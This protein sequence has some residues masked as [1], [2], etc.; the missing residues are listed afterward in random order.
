LLL[1]LASHILH[2][3]ELQEQDDMP[4]Q[5]YSFGSALADGELLPSQSARRVAAVIERSKSFEYIEYRKYVCNQKGEAAVI[6]VDCLNDKVPS[7]NNYGIKN[8]ERL[9]LVFFE[10]AEIAPEL[11][12]MRKNF[13]TGIHQNPTN[14]DEAI[15]LCLYEEP[16]TSTLRH[17]TAEAHLKKILW[18]LENASTGDLH[19]EGQSLE[20]FFYPS[21]MKLVLPPDFDLILEAEDRQLLVFPNGASLLAVWKEDIS[22]LGF[23]AKRAL[24]TLVVKITPIP[25][26]SIERLPF[27][28]GGLEKVICKRSG[29]LLEILKEQIR[30]RVPEKGL[31]RYKSQHVLLII[32]IPLCREVGQPAEKSQNVGFLIEDDI[33]ALGLALDVLH[34]NEAN[35]KF[36][37]FDLLGSQESPDSINWQ[38]MKIMPVDVMSANTIALA[39]TASAI[40]D[41]TANFKG[42]LAGV[43]ALGSSLA[44]LWALEGWGQ[45]TYVDNDN[46]ETHNILRH[47]AKYA[48]TGLN[49]VHAVAQEVSN[50]YY[51]KYLR[52]SAIVDSIINFTNPDVSEAISHADLLIDASTTLEAPREIALR[53]EAPRSMSAFITPN[54]FDSVL[55]VEDRNRGI[56]LDSLEAQYYQALLENDWGNNHLDK[57]KGDIWIGRGCRDISAVIPTE[58]I[59]LHSAMLARKIRFA[60]YQNNSLISIFHSNDETGVSIYEMEPRPSMIFNVLDWTILIDTGMTEVLQVMRAQKLP[61]ETGGVLLGFI[62]HK[63]NRIF[64]VEAL[65][66]PF[67]SDETKSSFVRGTDG[68]IAILDEARRR[69]AGLVTYLGEWHS[70]PPGCGATPSCLDLK[71]I[72]YLGCELAEDGQ[73][74]LM[75]IVGENEISFM[76]RADS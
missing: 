7:R 50:N 72:D 27:T 34:F 73:P 25:H 26:G 30:A 43:G 47:T 57:H 23:E 22:G 8:R 51:P 29:G 6:I 28:L 9:A 40:S 41:N 13:P 71:L 55:L 61:D 52:P 31:F 58:M 19:Q 59:Q 63:T 15:S 67:D 64:I 20:P 17:W 70:H 38:I 69:T 2:P 49:K 75:T 45:W 18:W 60:R 10:N 56:R 32:H 11:R 24:A 68:L 62:D 46:I 1:H 5:Y 36:F 42:V 16:W 12:A 39:R 66:A 21:G 35:N 3:E 53:D 74:A 54:G 4:D 65:A 48:D 14:E 37:K 44:E 33:C 76:L